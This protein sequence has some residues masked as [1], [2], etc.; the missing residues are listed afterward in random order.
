MLEEHGGRKGI[1]IALSAAGGPAHLADGAQ[2]GGGREPFVHETHRQAGPFLQLGSDVSDLD[3]A[4]RIVAVSIQRQA[5]HETL[6][7]E[8]S[9]A[10][11]HFGNWRPFP[12]AT[13]DEA[14][15]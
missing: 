10:S 1:D 14:S 4:R 13:V 8:I 3:R 6:D 15:R 11:N 7:L 12:A 2:G 9:S 5:E